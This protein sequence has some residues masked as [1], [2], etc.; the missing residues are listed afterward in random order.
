MTKCFT[1]EG[2][3]LKIAEFALIKMRHL[4]MSYLIWIYT[5]CHLYFEFS[6]CIAWTKHVP[7]FCRNKFCS[8]LFQHHKSLG[9]VCEDT[10]L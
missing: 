6:V 9:N 10:N 7:K 5:V 3:K 4:I 2:P 8:M 1:I